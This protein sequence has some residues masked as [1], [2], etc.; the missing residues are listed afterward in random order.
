MQ[1]AAST[2]GDH[3]TLTITGR[4]DTNT[5]PELQDEI[6]KAFQST[7]NVVLDFA[8]VDYISSAGLR[9]LL[10]GH[11]TAAA[12]KGSF[13]LTNVNAQVTAILQTVG[14]SKILAIR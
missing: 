9:A 13:A 8:G 2:E 12:K 4:V 10:I 1:I 6:T 11:K 7:K 5:S 3:T 14:F